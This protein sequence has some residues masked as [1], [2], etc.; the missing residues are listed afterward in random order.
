MV[1]ECAYRSEAFTVRRGLATGFE[2]SFS[3][4]QAQQPPS[5][6]PA[7]SFGTKGNVK[8]FPRADTGPLA[9]PYVQPEDPRDAGVSD[10]V[11]QEL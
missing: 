2:G 11:W 10:A 1:N 3:P 9:V 7:V 4:S 8:D 5:N 6:V